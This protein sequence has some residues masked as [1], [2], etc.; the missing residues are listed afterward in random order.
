MYTCAETVHAQKRMQTCILHGLR[1][2]C[3]LAFIWV[4]VSSTRSCLHAPTHAYRQAGSQELVQQ[5]STGM[6]E[7]MGKTV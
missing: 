5:S 6:R 7:F 4:Y 2:F 1:K 3:V